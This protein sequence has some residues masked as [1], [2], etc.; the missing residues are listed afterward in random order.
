MLL[1]IVKYSPCVEEE[2]YTGIVGIGRI[3]VW[4]LLNDMIDTR[5]DAIM[6][7]IL[8]ENPPFQPEEYGYEITEISKGTTLCV[9]AK[10]LDLIWYTR[11]KIIYRPCILY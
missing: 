8:K 9:L 7:S 2:I 1:I 6:S 4:K 10:G 5:D 11:T 3:S